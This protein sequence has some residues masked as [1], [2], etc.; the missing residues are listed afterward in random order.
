VSEDF[1]Q[2]GYGHHFRF[3]EPAELDAA[4]AALVREAYANGRQE[5]R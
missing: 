4:F 1:G 5:R 3:R 2:L